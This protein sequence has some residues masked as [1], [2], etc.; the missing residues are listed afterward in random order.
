MY[1]Y[2]NRHI[3]KLKAMVDLITYFHFQVQFYEEH[4]K[5]YSYF[6]RKL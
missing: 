1:I 4:K 5:K 6:R 2:D 3:I